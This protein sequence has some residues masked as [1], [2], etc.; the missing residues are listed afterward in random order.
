MIKEWSI[1]IP[2]PVFAL[3]QSWRWRRLVRKWNRDAPRIMQYIQEA[4]PGSEGNYD[5]T[6][7]Q[8]TQIVWQE[9]VMWAQLNQQVDYPDFVFMCTRRKFDAEQTKY[10]REMLKHLRLMA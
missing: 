4:A 7:F 2:N 5:S 10:V 1:V 8:W 6:H 9:L 3:V